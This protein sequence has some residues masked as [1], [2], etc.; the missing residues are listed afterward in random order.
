MLCSEFKLLIC[1]KKVDDPDLKVQERIT[2]IINNRPVFES[3]ADN[4]KLCTLIRLD[5]NILI[6]RKLI[7][8]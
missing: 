2:E 4:F 7:V 3:S 5:R 8:L 6:L 1:I